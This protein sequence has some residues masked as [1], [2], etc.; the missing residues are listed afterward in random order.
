MPVPLPAGVCERPVSCAEWSHRR[1]RSL[2][3]LGVAVRLAQH[4]AR[5]QTIGWGEY[6]DEVY[7]AQGVAVVFVVK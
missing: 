7:Q 3:R 5:H 6:L 4:G 2:W 1:R